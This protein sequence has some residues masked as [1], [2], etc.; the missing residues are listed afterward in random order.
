MVM[1]DQNILHKMFDYVLPQE[2]FD[3]CREIAIQKS[4][5]AEKQKKQEE[6]GRKRS[7]EKARKRRRTENKL[8]DLGRLNPTK[9]DYYNSEPVRVFRSTEDPIGYMERHGLISHISGDDYHWFESSPGTSIVFVETTMKVYSSSPKAY[10]PPNHGDDDPIDGHRFII[11]YEYGLDV[12]D[13]TQRDEINK[14]LAAD[15][16]GTYTP[17]EV[18]QDRNSEIN[19]IGL[20]ENLVSPEEVWRP[21]RRMEIDEEKRNELKDRQVNC[22]K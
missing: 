21:E 10:F 8:I 20:Q 22:G 2:V 12:K 13:Y 3:E 16:Y 18:V 6:V 5:A 19:R 14:C 9:Y 1:L 15:G 17:R 11:S 7:T 4:K